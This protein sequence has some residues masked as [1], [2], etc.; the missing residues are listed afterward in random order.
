MN[1]AC[2]YCGQQTTARKAR[3]HQ[4]ACPLRPM[5]MSEIIDLALGI[6]DTCDIGFVPHDWLV[7]HLEN[8]A[9][10]KGREVHRETIEAAI[11]I[12]IKEYLEG[13]RWNSYE[14]EIR[15]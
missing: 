7:D 12:A 10:R 3:S 14:T 5:S 4:Q 2:P 8:L 1:T 6:S 13:L 15:P 11:P 9:H